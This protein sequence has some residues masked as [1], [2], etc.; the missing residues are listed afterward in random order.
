MNK[1]KKSE[2]GVNFNWK[3]QIVKNVNR[4][5]S[6]YHIVTTTEPASKNNTTRLREE[7]KSQQK[8]RTNRTNKIYRIR[9]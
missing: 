1:R 3:Q 8:E 6:H 2:D 9:I 4:R 7:R 5:T